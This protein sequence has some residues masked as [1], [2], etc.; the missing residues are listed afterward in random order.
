VNVR[1]EQVTIGIR[2]TDVWGRSHPDR[3]VVCLIEGAVKVGA[4][5]EQAVTLDKPRQFYRRD[6]GKTQP[7]GLV[8]ANQIA[9]WSKQTEIEAGKGALRRGGRFSVQLAAADKEEAARA[10]RDQLRAAGYPAEVARRKEAD[11]PIH[12]VRIG[13]LPS[14]DDAQALARQLKGRFGVQEPKVSP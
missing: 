3:Q 1:V 9:E 8:G 7:V 14:R 2:G 6:M 5:G 11:K 4:E 13:Q 10:V 12:V